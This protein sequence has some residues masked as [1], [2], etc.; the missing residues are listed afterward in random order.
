MPPIQAVLDAFRSHAIVALADSHG[1]E[2]IE[3]EVL[4][5]QR[6]ALVIYG[7]GHLFRMGQSLVSLLSG[8]AGRGSLPSRQPES[9]R[10]IW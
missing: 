6:R 10:L 7:G 5:K 3:R 4:A 1:N 8:M 2:Q 9:P